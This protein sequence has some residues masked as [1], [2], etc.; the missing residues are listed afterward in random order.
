MIIDEHEGEVARHLRFLARQS[1]TIANRA[2][3]LVRTEITRKGKRGV[4]AICDK[5]IMTPRDYLKT[6]FM[7]ISVLSLY[8]RYKAVRIHTLAEVLAMVQKT[9][10]KENLI[11]DIRH[12]IVEAAQ[13]THVDKKEDDDDLTFNFDEVKGE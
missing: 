4:D 12:L 3:S 8:H 6:A 11:H 9:T 13:S 1:E 7:R 10:N 2:R 5:F